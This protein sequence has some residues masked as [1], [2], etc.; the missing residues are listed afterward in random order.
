MSLITSAKCV[1]LHLTPSYNA[2]VV[3]AMVFGCVLWALLLSPIPLVV[4]LLIIGMGMALPMQQ[5]LTPALC[6]NVEIDFSGSVQI[7]DE[8]YAISRVQYLFAFAFI[9]ME[10]QGRRW[11]LWR[12]SCPEREYR[13][14]LVRLKREL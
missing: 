3:A 13:Q 5:W 8:R 4:T 7:G 11:L 1:K 2:R 6:G 14:L 12:D 10:G 9:V